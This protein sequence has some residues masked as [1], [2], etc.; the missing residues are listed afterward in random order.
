M[1]AVAAA[2]AAGMLLSGCADPAEPAS[3]S[4]VPDPEPPVET[5]PEPVDGRESREVCP[6]LDTQWV[7]NTNGQR[8]T[9]VALD[10]R[11]EVPACVF[12][13]YPEEPQLQ[14]MVRRMPSV[15]DAIAV[16][17]WAAPIDH[18]EPADEPAGWMGGRAGA[19]MI[20][21]RSGAVFAVQKD[22]VAVVVLTNQEQSFK[23]QQVGEETIGN[24]GL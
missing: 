20:P 3:T 4:E 18:T 17:D 7:E 12:W 16:V 14:V 23:A 22:N 1:A 24:L 8:V 5:L 21:E 13:S 15:E 6:Y 10:Q 2:V 9:G 11:F 19:G